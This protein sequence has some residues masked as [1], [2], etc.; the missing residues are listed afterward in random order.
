MGG[1]DHGPSVLTDI[2]QYTHNIVGGIRI[3]VPGRF[4]GQD[5][6]RIV[7]Q[8]THDRL[9]AEGGLYGKLVEAQEIAD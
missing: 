3:K 8:G 4:I 6:L 5:D 9:I 7:Q 2:G 1:H